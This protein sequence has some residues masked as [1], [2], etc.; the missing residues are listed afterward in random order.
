MTIGLDLPLGATG[1]LVQQPDDSDLFDLPLLVDWETPG[2]PPAAP[3]G[4]KPKKRKSY[5]KKKPK[6]RKKAK[7]KGPGQGKRPWPWRPKRTK[8]PLRPPRGGRATHLMGRVLQRVYGTA[9]T[10]SLCGRWIEDIW[11]GKRN[12]ETME[13]V[14]CKRCQQKHDKILAR[15]AAGL[16]PVRR[17]GRQP[18]QLPL[19]L[20]DHT[21]AAVV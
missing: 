4:K 7:K 13:G 10:V 16:P 8:P 6:R 5:Y 15:Q 3:K 18:E 14:T 17:P 20:R 21:D 1:T 19:V 12:K 2:L 11:T 9:E